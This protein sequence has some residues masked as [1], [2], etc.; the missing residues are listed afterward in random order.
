MISPIESMVLYRLMK[1]LL[2]EASM[3]LLPFVTAK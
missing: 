1:D 2:P 3:H